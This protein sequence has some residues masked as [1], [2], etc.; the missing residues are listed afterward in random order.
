MKIDV[1]DVSSV[2][3]A[4]CEKE[5]DTDEIDLGKSSSIM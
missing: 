4:W 1:S 5:D 3:E 2:A